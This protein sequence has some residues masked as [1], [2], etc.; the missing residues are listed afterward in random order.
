MIARKPSVSLY[1]L[2][3]SNVRTTAGWLALTKGL[4][5]F[6]KSYLPAS[7]IEKSAELTHRCEPKD[8]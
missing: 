7:I 1:Y 8:V 4:Y 5:A 6:D 3:S 2:V